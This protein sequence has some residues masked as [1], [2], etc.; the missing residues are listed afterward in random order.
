VSPPTGAP[1]PSNLAGWARAREVA[2][3]GWRAAGLVWQTSPG[4][5]V[6]TAVL[7]VVGGLLPAG[8]AWVGKQI[9]DGVLLARETGTSEARLDTLQWVAL[10][11][12]LVVLLA[13]MRRA[14]DVGDTLMRAT[15]GNTV[16]VMILRKALELELPD[17]EDSE[18]Y[19]RMT[20]ARREASRRPLSLVR[21]GLGLVQNGVSLLS[22][23]AILLA[24]SPLAV[25]GLSLAAL[26]AFLAETR[27]AGEAFALFSWRSPEVRMQ[28][29]L[30]VVVAREDHAKEVKLLG[31]GPQLVERY[32][33]IFQKLFADERGLVLR[34]GAWALGLGALSTLALYVAYGWIAATAVAGTITLGQMTLYLLVFKQG[35]SAFGASLQAL[36]GIYEDSLYMADLY[37]F[38]GLPV[39]RPGGKA[40]AGPDPADGVRFRDVAFTYPGAAAA[41]VQGVNL[42]IAPGTRLALVGH[43][44]SGKTTLIKLL[45]GLYV[46]TEGA[47]SLDGL[48]LR[49]WD[50][51][52]LRGRL[53]VIFQDFVKY[54]LT[55]GENIGVGDRDHLTDEA[56]QREAADKGMATPFIDQMP[57][58]FTTQL[59]KWFKDGRELSTGQW[60]K[61][62]LARAFMREGAD[63]L[64]LDEPTSAM[65]AEAEAQ[66][67]DRVRQLTS[68]QIAVLISHRFSTVRMADRIVVLEGGGV[69]EEGDHASLMANNGRYAR[70]FS[71]QAEGYR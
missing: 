27:F 28:S 31:I 34:R 68:G 44:G 59:G 62:A 46:P 1:R 42:H 61:V 22:Y 57:G 13:A 52:A 41:A 2:R 16:N 6:A 38:L 23:A 49:S 67:F 10:E 50:P 43:N 51:S 36:G 7:T 40:T 69:M 58:G 66:I 11:G 54:Q 25:L 5:F 35:Q 19:D 33:R 53:G 37:E 71:L 30:E 32:D 47:V 14:V 56:R 8:V 26:P 12:G 70:L 60:Q 48:D 15:L 9:V 4:L 65:D 45:T 18:I 55:V 63:V 39:V 64:V 20:R 24:F 21:Q 17:F 29:Y 3:L